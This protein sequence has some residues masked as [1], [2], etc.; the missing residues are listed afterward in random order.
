MGAGWLK[1]VWS[2]HLT[3]KSGL[4][5]FK[6][7]RHLSRLANW[8]FRGEIKLTEMQMRRDEA[9]GQ[10]NWKVQGINP[11]SA[12]SINC[13]VTLLHVHII[14]AVG[15]STGPAGTGYMRTQTRQA[16]QSKYPRAAHHTCQNKPH[17]VIFVDSK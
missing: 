10:Q 2:H 8:P 1:Q 3:G 16:L 14:A 13:F 5:E 11:V 15:L 17:P 6:M 12:R 7:L 4:R 9:P